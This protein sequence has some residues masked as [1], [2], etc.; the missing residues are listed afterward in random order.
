MCRV[1][2]CG[3][4]S[5]SR[6]QF[7]GQGPITSGHELLFGTVRKTREAADILIGTLGPE[8][9]G[10]V[11][12]PLLA[13]ALLVEGAGERLGVGVGRDAILEEAATAERQAD[14]L[15]MLNRLE[16]RLR[17]GRAAIGP[18]AVPVRPLVRV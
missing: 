12:G 17:N 10:Q 8:G 2:W 4:R 1:M 9:P 14:G 3:P 11:P 6:H 16:E 15:N 7:R 13:S 18:L 5:R